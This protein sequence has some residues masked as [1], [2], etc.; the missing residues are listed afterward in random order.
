VSWR[1]TGEE[2]GHW[3]PVFVPGRPTMDEHSGTVGKVAVFVGRPPPPVD[4]R[5]QRRMVEH[6]VDPVPD[7]A[8]LQCRMVH[9]TAAGMP[10]NSQPRPT[11]PGQQLSAASTWSCKINETKHNFNWQTFLFFFGK[12]FSP[13]CRFS[14]NYFSFARL[15]RCP[16]YL[17][18]LMIDH[19]WDFFNENNCK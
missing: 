18:N 13:N 4:N 2:M 6:L 7:R 11:A 12:T 15:A 17:C 3:V 8:T 10:H 5:D 16:C 19:F 9:H 14:F 1:Q